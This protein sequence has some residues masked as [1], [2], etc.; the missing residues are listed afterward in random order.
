M[1]RM[2]LRRNTRTHYYLYNYFIN[3]NIPLV[4]ILSMVRFFQFQNRFIISMTRR[5]ELF[6]YLCKIFPI[7]T[8]RTRLNI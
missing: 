5:I 2:T 1:N 8:I 6:Y 7:L 3:R 4:H